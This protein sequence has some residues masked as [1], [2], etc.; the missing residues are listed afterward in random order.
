[1]IGAVL[2]GAIGVEALFY[3][4]NDG[5]FMPSTHFSKYMT[6][7]RFKGIKRY[8]SEAFANRDLLAENAWAMFD[9]AVSW[10]NEN[11]KQ[12][13]IRSPEIIGDESMS[14]FAPQTTKKGGLPN[15]SYIQRKP[16]PLGTE[17]KDTCDALT[18]M[19]L[20]LEIQKA[21]EAQQGME[22]AGD[23]DKHGRGVGVLAAT[24]LRLALASV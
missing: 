17:F 19:M 24:G 4:S 9:D 23:I 10:Y 21:E 6:F 12:N 18:G 14:Q 8:I 22:F 3:P 16:R 15:I 7:L 13:I 5:L 20:H 11:R 2:T 1:M